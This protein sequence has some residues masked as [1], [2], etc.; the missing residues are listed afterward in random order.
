MVLHVHHVPGR[1]RVRLRALRRNGSAVAPLR[2]KLLGLPGVRSAS[3]NPWTGSII[4]HYD[5]ASF[6]PETVWATLRR[7]GHVEQAPQHA[8]ADLADT[9]EALVSAV[10]S[11]IADA[12]ATAALEHLL[13]RSAGAVIR[14]LV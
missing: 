8:C 4:I 5:H 2:S 6:E 13:G 3:I 12:L 7:L 10:A 14:L 1:L 9:G 11:S